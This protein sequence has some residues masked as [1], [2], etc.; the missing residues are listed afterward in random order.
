MN[1]VGYVTDGGFT[2]IAGNRPDDKD[3]YTTSLIRFNKP[4][5]K[6][7]KKITGD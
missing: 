6:V 1:D 7:D 2:V 4:N 5:K 3:A